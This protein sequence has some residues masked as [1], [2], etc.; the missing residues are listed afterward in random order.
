[1][2]LTK[3]GYMVCL[4]AAIL[5]FQV[6]ISHALLT[7]EKNGKWNLI[8]KI[9][10]EATFR[11]ADAPPN[12]PIPIKT[13]DLITQRNLL[14][15]EFK[16]DLG[17]IWKDIELGYYCQGRAY[18]DSAWDYSIDA[19]SNDE[20]RQ[21]YG[22][23]NRDQIDKLKMDADVFMAYG[24]LTYGPLFTRFGRQVMAWGEMST[25]R[26]LDGTN[27]MDTSSLS[28]DLM[29]RLVPVWLIRGNL[30]F[31][32]VGPFESLSVEGYYINGQIDNTNGEE[33]IDGSPVHPPISG[34]PTGGSEVDIMA[35]FMASI[36]QVPDDLEDDRYGLKL[37]LMMGGLEFNFAYYRRYSS[38]P[39][40]WIDVDGFRPGPI[41]AASLSPE[42][43]GEVFQG[44]NVVLG[45]DT[46]DVYGTSFNYH[47]N[48]I[49]TVVRGE[50]AIS[51]G[52][53]MMTPGGLDGVITAFEE[54]GN[55][56]I[57][58]MGDMTIEELAG[59]FIRD[60]NEM[61]PLPFSL[62]GQTEKYDVWKF[63]IGFD[64]FMKVPFFNKEDFMFTLEY[65][66]SKIMNFENNAIMKPWKAPWDDDQDVSFDTVWETEYSNTFVFITNTYYFNGNMNPQCVMMYEVEPKAL[67]LMPSVSYTMGN[68]QYKVSLF[69]TES[70]SYEG[71]MGMLDDRD[72]MTFSVTYDF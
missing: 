23:D 9:K 48:F 63:G 13:G 56:Q 35:Q 61:G 37:G 38:I 49:D 30:A 5:S 45:I 57:T 22:Y 3:R 2:K 55:I 40:A 4:I 62:P 29:E 44:L 70:G 27:P 31:D 72:E 71:T 28:V 19:L 52:V 12:N 50:A 26:I 34:S 15:M 17:N 39:V 58:G 41:D 32:Y 42:S 65:V 10:P 1:M 14:M 6:G 53:P 67:T 33:M 18:Y 43:F 59:M 51:K 68:I 20:L 54:A 11:I 25:I 46:V 7:D 47:W 8:G 66:G 21:E 24:D 69:I 64:K 36:A 60:L 16:H